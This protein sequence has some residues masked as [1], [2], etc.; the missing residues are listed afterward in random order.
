MKFKAQYLDGE[1]PIE[2]QIQI[3]W[4]KDGFLL[5]LENKSLWWSKGDASV[6]FYSNS[7]RVT[8][9]SE[10][11]SFSI[12]NIDSDTAA[13]FQIR[14]IEG[15]RTSLRLQKASLLLLMTLA[16]FASVYTSIRPLS[17]TLA[18]A[19][20]PEE[21]R[22]VF[23]HLTPLT[24]LRESRCTQ[25]DA[26]SIV[27]NLGN[28]LAIPNEVLPTVEILQW[29]VAN[30]FAFP[31][32]RV[33]VTQGLIESLNSSEE[34]LAVLAHEYGHVALKHNVG[35]TISNLLKAY[36]WSIA[37][38]DFSGAFVIDPKLAKDMSDASYSR[39]L[40]TAADEYAAAQ[41][42]VKQHDPKAL[43][44]AL[45]AISAP[46]EN[47]RSDTPKIV[48]EILKWYESIFSTH[49]KTMERVRILNMMYPN[50]AERQP[51]DTS[52]WNFLKS[53][54]RKRDG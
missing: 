32:H 4:F 34:L 3:D 50:A 23:D 38:G 14:D 30:A 17:Y 8:H 10:L 18:R 27:Q 53:A 5:T 48:L 35:E 54:C 45:I 28:T 41:L 7:L 37:M 19:V 11:K 36:L 52:T 40:E 29:S 13:L 16:T 12:H 20:S 22:D 44:K 39:E 2:H 6:E 31:G 47:S 42:L 15:V 43:G 49:P 51:L 25:Q 26:Q 9:K 33:Y 24:V 46:H 1:S 21:E